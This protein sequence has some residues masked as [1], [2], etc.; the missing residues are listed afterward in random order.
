VSSF[1]DFSTI[2]QRFSTDVSSKLSRLKIKVAYVLFY[3]KQAHTSLNET[4]DIKASLVKEVT[5][6]NAK[7]LNELHE[8]NGKKVSFRY[9]LLVTILSETAKECLLHTLSTTKPL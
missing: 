1:E 2:T 7:M 6:D 4:A 9:K 3:K 5:G 8:S